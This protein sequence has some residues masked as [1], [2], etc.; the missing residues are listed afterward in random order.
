MKSN[1]YVR[2]RKSKYDEDYTKTSKARK[3]FKNKV[4]RALDKMFS[5]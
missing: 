2:I 5:E 3:M 4:R 1:I